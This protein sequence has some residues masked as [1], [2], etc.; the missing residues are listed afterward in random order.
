MKSKMVVEIHHNSYLIESSIKIDGQQ[1]DK[2]GE[3]IFNKGRLQMWVGTLFQTL[4]KEL[5]E[6]EEIE[7]NFQGLRTGYEDILFAA[8]EF[9]KDEDVIIK[10]NLTSEIDSPEKCLERLDALMGEAS[11][12]PLKEVLGKAL[13][14]LKSNYKLASNKDFEINVV[15]TMSSGKS[16][17]INSMLGNELLPAANEATTATMTYIYDESREEGYKGECFDNE[18]NSIH[19]IQPVDNEKLKEWNSSGNNK[20]NEDS[21]VVKASKIKIYGGI[22]YINK[23]EHSRLVFVDTPGP[24]NSQNEE[25]GKI[26]QEAIASEEMPMII[27]VLN[28]TSIGSDDDKKL[29]DSIKDVI[30]KSRN[31]KQAKDR[32]IFVINKADQINPE[33]GECIDSIVQNVESY[34]GI[35]NAT[36]LP[37]CAT[38]T[39]WAR[40]KGKLTRSEKGDFN[41][42]K[43]IFTYD[44]EDSEYEPV[45]FTK[46]MNV[47]PSI[48]KQCKVLL[49]KATKNNDLE[50]QAS[51]RTG[52]P[53]LELVISEYMN[54]Y[55][56]I[57]RV[58]NL[59][60]VMRVEMKEVQHRKESI[61]KLLQ[62]TE[63]EVSS[64]TK[65]IITLINKVKK[66]ESTNSFREKIK[67]ADFVSKVDITDYIMSATSEIGKER[68]KKFISIGNSFDKDDVEYDEALKLKN[69]AEDEYKGYRNKILVLLEKHR[70][71]YL[72][73]KLSELWKEYRQVVSGLFD[74]SENGIEIPAISSMRQVADTIVLKEPKTHKKSV[75]VGTERRSKWYNP[76]TWGDKI[77]IYKDRKY[78]KPREM[79]SSMQKAF[80]KDFDDIYKSI[81]LDIESELKN[82]IEEFTEK[83]KQVEEEI[84]TSITKHK[85]SLTLSK[86]E[87]E[88]EIYKNK[89][90]LKLINKFSKDLEKALVFN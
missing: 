28:A 30:K 7:L 32:V 9:E 89:S 3:K 54:K 46:F 85:E 5:K 53:V 38:A 19:S 63:G 6:P 14:S 80:I 25:H 1:D 40:T 82:V 12:E 55:S 10:V 49:D 37:I 67:K 69:I 4:Y 81:R 47:S 17:I 76:F 60:E 16:T 65:E 79:W 24:N 57:R 74:P 42:I 21:G 56:L 26:T 64:L 86:E 75:K 62:T 23:N 73:D 68:M 39:L 33:K 71:E 13:C 70:E 78:A 87:K 52:I 61:E 31:D 34:L 11:S 88:K 22:P 41:K 58:E 59:Y 50:L 2:L 29:L 66:G 18:S 8:Q 43:D 20:L 90:D 51:I 77:D 35:S 48:K 44:E 83:T 15:A 72:K 27:Y 45:D 84:I 36:I